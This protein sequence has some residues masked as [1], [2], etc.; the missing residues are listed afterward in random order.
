MKT[1]REKTAEETRTMKILLRQIM[2]QSVNAN[3]DQL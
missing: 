1:L 2:I 3:E